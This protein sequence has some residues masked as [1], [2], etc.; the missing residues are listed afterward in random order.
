M[1]TRIADTP[2]PIVGVPE[3]LKAFPIY[4]YRATEDGTEVPIRTRRGLQKVRRIALVGQDRREPC[5]DDP[6]LLGASER[7]WPAISKR[8][9]PRAL[10]HATE[11]ARSGV[12][13]L[14]HEVDE[15]AHLGQPLGW[16]LAQSIDELRVNRR[17]ERSFA[18]DRMIAQARELSRRLE[19]A[20]PELAAALIASSSRWEPM[21]L[22][23]LLHAGQDLIEGVTHEGPRAFSQLH[24]GSTKIR[25]D[26]SEILRTA[27]LPETD[28]IRLGIVRA[29]RFGVS[30]VI[31]RVAD[32][33]VRLD[34]LPG[35][36]LVPSD[37]SVAYRLTEAGVPVVILEN[38]QAAEALASRRP[39]AGI[40][41]SAG[42]PSQRTMQHMEQIALEA[43]RV[44]IIPDADLGGVRIAQAILGFL[45]VADVVD[46]GGHPH[47]R[48]EPF[49]IDGTSRPGLIAAAEGPAGVLARSVLERGYPVEQEMS[50]MAAVRAWLAIDEVPANQSD[51]SNWP[52]GIGPS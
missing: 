44:V 26:V 39:H 35:L 28:L 7:R 43:G 9:G 11:L 1:T 33:D 21:R 15:K 30:G 52:A 32:E 16:R 51:L 25:D 47:S 19:L 36:V 12:V 3:G 37:E 24:Y 13:L 29:T 17:N 6:F 2:I 41:Y 14:F 50:T 23:V 4:D 5:L 46:I 38:L 27:G 10:T 48:R 42:I 8:Y 45:P 31:A 20:A 40:I 34:L 49:P 18:R 22:E